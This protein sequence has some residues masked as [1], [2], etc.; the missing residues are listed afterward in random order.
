MG[1]REREREGG[2][3]GGGGGGILVAQGPI[4]Y[5]V[6]PDPRDGDFLL[7]H[8]RSPAISLRLTILGEIFADMTVFNPTIKVVTFGLRG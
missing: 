8:L 7:L 5:N 6:Y 3:G 4:T 1:E 2:G